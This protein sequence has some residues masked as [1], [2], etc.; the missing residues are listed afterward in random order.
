MLEPAQPLTTGLTVIVATT[1]EDA[2]FIAVKDGMLSAPDDARP[3]DDILLVQL[4][5]VPLTAPL[6]VTG[7]VARP[8]HRV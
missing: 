3:T 4:K 1:G 7:V 5:A 8:L 6:N 2:V